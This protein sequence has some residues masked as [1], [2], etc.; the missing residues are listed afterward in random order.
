M[1]EPLISVP[2]IERISYRRYEFVYQ[3]NP[4]KLYEIQKN[5]GIA[6]AKVLPKRSMKNIGVSLMLSRTAS[7]QL[8]KNSKRGN[9]MMNFM[10]LR[11]GKSPLVRKFTNST[12]D[13]VLTKIELSC[14]K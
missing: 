2:T 12:F 11:Y 4:E 14:K 3:V 10:K 13:S 1:M 8:K 5:A 7:N 6:R 9:A